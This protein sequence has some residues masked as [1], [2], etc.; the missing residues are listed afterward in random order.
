M[1]DTTLRPLYPGKH[2]VSIVQEA[3]W[4][5]GPARKISPPKLYFRS[6]LPTYETTQRRIPEYGSFNILQRK[7]L[8][9]NN[10]GVLL[11]ST[12]TSILCSCL[13]QHA[14]VCISYVATSWRRLLRRD[15]MT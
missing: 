14:W 7:K 2:L 1:V 11:P 12:V 15:A 4:V 8:T 5:S 9:F 6:Q 10:T 3:G 13:L